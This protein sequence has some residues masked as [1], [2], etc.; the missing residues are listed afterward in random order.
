MCPSRPPPGDAPSAGPE[1]AG[2]ESLTGVKDRPRRRPGPSGSGA[3]AGGED[4]QRQ[5]HPAAPHRA[6]GTPAFRGTRTRPQPRGSQPH[7]AHCDPRRTCPHLSK[8]PPR[9]AITRSSCDTPVPPP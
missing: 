7:A 5:G 9:A 6:S 2:G 1:A 8:P 3:G 4:V